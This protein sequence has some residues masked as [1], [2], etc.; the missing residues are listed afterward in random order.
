[1]QKLNISKPHQIENT[2]NHGKDFWNYRCDKLISNMAPLGN[3]VNL[4]NVQ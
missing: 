4:V 3:A 1:M 2:D